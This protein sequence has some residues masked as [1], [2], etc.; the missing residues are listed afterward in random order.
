M[1]K[2][3]ILDENTANKIA[4]GEVVERPASVV[5][6]LV[7][8]SID[9]GAESI[10]IEIKNGGISYIKVVDNGSGIEEDD[11]E[12]AFERHATSKI[13]HAD[14][15]ESIITMGF[16]GEALASIAAVS[17]VEV[18][19][20]VREKPHG[21]Y[22]KI[23]GGT[24]QDV[25][26]TGCPV[27][28]TFIVRDLFYN[29][30]A[31]FKF[32]KK[33]STEAGYV[34]DLVSRIALANPHISFRLVSNHSQVLHTPGNNDLLSTIFSVY[35]KEVAR[36]V[37]R[38]DYEE[39]GIR[40]TGYAGK[41]EIARGTRSHQTIFVNGRYIKSKLVS[42]AIDEA[43]KTLLMKNKFAFIVLNIELNPLLI[44][45]N[46]HPTKMEVRF[47]EEQKIFRIVYHAVNNALLGTS[48]I[49]TVRLESKD[50]NIFKF[51]GFEK[52]N[53][54]FLQQDIYS[55]INPVL[56]KKKTGTKEART[57]EAKRHEIEGTKG[58]NYIAG[59][60]PAWESGTGRAA[61]R[62]SFS[63][64][65]GAQKT[66]TKD[67][68]AS[69]AWMESPGEKYNFPS[70][71]EEEIDEREITDCK[72][73]TT[74]IDA[75]E[76]TAFKDGAD[77]SDGRDITAYKV[78]ADKPDVRDITAY[79]D[80]ADKSNVGDITAYKSE[81]DKSNVGDITAYKG[82]ADKSNV[83][84]ITAYKGEAGESGTRDVSVF[85]GETERFN[86]RGITAYE[87]EA[88]KIDINEFTA[89]EAGSIK[90][91]AVESVPSVTGEDEFEEDLTLTNETGIGKAKAGYE[92]KAS[93]AI[94]EDVKFQS[95]DAET[96]REVSSCYGEKTPEAEMSLSECTLVGQAFSTYIILQHKDELMLIDQHAAH[97]RITYEA[98]KKKFM[99]NESLSQELLAPIVIEVTN[100][101]LKLLQE[102]REF[103]NK[104]GFIYEDFGNNS[105]ILRSV[106]FA[107]ID[108]PVKSVFL[109]VVDSV[110]KAGKDNYR[111]IADD[112]IYTMAC[113]AAVKAN[114]RLDEMEIRKILE[115][116]DK[117]E[118]P[119]TCPH[120]R[121]TIVRLT[122]YEL[123]KMFKRI[124]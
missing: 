39:S 69:N 102:E 67:T 19:T 65:T 71:A 35:G 3:I 108:E 21:T 105:I 44:D 55:G 38:I 116:L 46:V 76:V 47:S 15:L 2:V 104:L 88:Q 7:E 24:V 9:A 77:K 45:I 121:P 62:E 53:G 122:K 51:D 14:D 52:A 42:S 37:V 25:R 59:E 32:L 83:G 109:D 117:L 103:F 114:K 80:E 81:A 106:P 93:L 8:N 11:L 101:E 6:E 94:D 22:I 87:R 120:G 96:F 13:R 124:V 41:P 20:R 28:T 119:Y 1:G 115:D 10:S 110:T 74:K 95:S 60:A 61:A 16:R 113:K 49:R 100:Q 31:R 29:T 99:D 54:D 30:P 4:A 107:C 112:A 34:S 56:D 82:E 123:E 111:K 33:D 118:N 5:K 63:N 23:Q 58:A 64:I 50:S 92:E 89:S 57:E 43:Y 68:T 90:H 78:E 27:G 91:G 12:I 66:S 36:Q 17:T 18:S 97:E 98:M 75:R 73:E 26:Q 70:K 79:K 86:A 40:V 85:K 48:L 84:D 72:D